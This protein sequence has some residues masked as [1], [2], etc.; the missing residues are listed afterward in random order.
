MEQKRLYGIL[1]VGVYLF[2]MSAG[3]LSVLAQNPFY[4]PDSLMRKYNVQTATLT[5][6]LL[7]NNQLQGQGKVQTSYVFSRKGKVIKETNHLDGSYI[8]YTYNSLEQLEKKIYYSAQNKVE[9]M[10][11]HLRTYEGRLTAIHTPENKKTYTYNAQDQL[12]KVQ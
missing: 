12:V 8:K 4:F 3:C 11:A 5:T 9:I 7:A 1:V 6:Y 10:E 2:F